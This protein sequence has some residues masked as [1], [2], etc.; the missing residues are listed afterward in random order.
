MSSINPVV[1]QDIQNNYLE[2]L[3]NKIQ[4]KLSTVAIVG[5]GYVGLPNVVSKAREG[6]KVIAYDLDINK[7]ESISAGISYISDV[8]NSDLEALVL[9]GR[10]VATN[11]ASALSEANII[12]ICVPT[13]IDE[14]KQPNLS[15]IKSA[16]TT[17]LNNVKKGTLIILESTT[18]PGTTEEYIVNSLIKEGFEVGSDIFVAYSPERID[19]S[20][21]AY[22]V[23]NTPRIVGGHTENCTEIS[24]LY[25]GDTTMKVTSTKIA[26]MSKVYEN[27]F[28]YVNIALANELALICNKMNMDAWEVIEASSTKPFGFMPFYPSSGIGGHCIPVDP[29][30]L[31]YKA[32][33]YDYTTKLI[34]I[35]GDLDTH[36]KEYTVNKMIK[37][38]NQA[39]QP[40]RK[41][42]IAILGVTYK[43][44]V[45]DSR[46]SFIH[47]LLPILEEYGADITLIDPHVEKLETD[48]NI[49][50]IEEIDYENLK[51]FDLV[52]ILTDHSKFDYDSILAN[53]FLVF[54][55]KNACKKLEIEGV[56]YK[57]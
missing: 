34:D 7:I 32:K 27:T 36:M 33:E 19:P 16:M 45:N 49:Y 4:N 35:A 12:T 3:K 42:K 22:N 6:Y 28:R 1:N 47:K 20:N 41:S 17:I 14:F 9:S 54:D 40:I 2:E 24:S 26:E 44:D 56:Y 53:S 31:S 18:Y 8:S 39:G 57:L 51:T 25:L 37:I 23:D 29:Y 55:T 30:Y 52:V 50:N 48:N 11:D 21:S 46:E 5:L 10:I 38:L 15:F 13:P 43:K